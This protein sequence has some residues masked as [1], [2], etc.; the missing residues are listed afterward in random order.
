VTE[1]APGAP[2]RIVEH[3]KATG[4]PLPGG[5]VIP[6]VVETAGGV[7]VRVRFDGGG[8]ATFLS[9]SGWTAW[10][11]RHRWRLL[12]PEDRPC[13]TGEETDGAN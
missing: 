13:G 10:G 1:W 8:P 3:D 7:Y 2:A 12:P 5:R 6:A 9:G 11:E 4:R